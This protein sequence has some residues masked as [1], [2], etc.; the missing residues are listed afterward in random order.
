MSHDSELQQ[1]VLAEL[2]WEPGVTSSHIGVTANAGVV[3]LTGHVENFSEKHVAEIA[4][5]RVRGVKAVAEDL[6]VRLPFARKRGDDEIAA[7][8][9]ERLAWDASIPQDRFKIVVENGWVTLSG[10]ADWNYQK[11]AAQQD[12]AILLG[13][14]GVSN[15][16]LIKAKVDTLGLSDEITHALHRS[17][18]F[19]DNNIKV[20]AIGGRVH[21]TGTVH[22]S[23]ERQTA[24]EAAW[25]APGS[26]NVENDIV[27]I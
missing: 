12:I 25:A 14:V 26:T 10:M 16:I 8:A 15:Q 7:A 11:I 4:T 24:A 1:A 5:R 20:T 9:L 3:T 21:L 13:V 6:E 22:S 27:V 17:W 18:F 2:S 19:D 23:Y